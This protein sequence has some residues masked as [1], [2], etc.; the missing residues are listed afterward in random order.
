[1]SITALVYGY[2]LDAD[3]ARGLVFND[4]TIGGVKLN[5][6]RYL[7]D[8]PEDC[9]AVYLNAKSLNGHIQSGIYE[10]W[11]RESIFYLPSFCFRDVFYIF[12]VL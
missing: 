7:S 10:I 6:G 8:Y 2:D 5:D 1:V 11:P 12:Y 4:S 9:A 3:L